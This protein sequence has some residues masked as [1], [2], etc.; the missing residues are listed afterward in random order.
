MHISINEVSKFYERI[1]DV[2]FGR[3]L[4]T[5]RANGSANVIIGSL[6]RESLTVLLAA[7]K[8]ANKAPQFNFEAVYQRYKGFV[9]NMQKM[10][11]PLI[12]LGR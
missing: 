2:Q 9:L 1:S 7:R 10:L 6:P 5:V 11:Q 12:E 8:I 3:L 4:D